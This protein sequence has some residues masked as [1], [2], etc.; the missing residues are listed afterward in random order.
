MLL[1]FF[2]SFRKY[3]TFLLLLLFFQKYI[4]WRSNRRLRGKKSK[5]KENK[6]KFLCFIM[7]MIFFSLKFNG[8]RK[9]KRIFSVS[10]RKSFP[11]ISLSLSLSLSLYIF[12]GSLLSIHSHP[13]KWG[14]NNWYLNF[15]RLESSSKGIPAERK[16]KI[17]SRTGCSDFYIYLECKPLNVKAFAMDI[18]K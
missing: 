12:P 6:A 18:F 11:L 7:V 1:G 10:Y 3:V 2:L 15:L 4:I 13:I 16:W 17:Y 5:E 14:Y 9:K 8:G